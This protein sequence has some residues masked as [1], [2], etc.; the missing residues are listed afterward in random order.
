MFIFFQ[1]DYACTFAHHE[2]IAVLVVGA[3]CGFGTVII[4]GVQR[5]RL[6]KPGYA[7]RTDCPF[8]AACDHHVRIVVTDHACGIANRMRAG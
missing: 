2:T 6:R 3:A 7:K 1:D 5:T 4:A 8:R